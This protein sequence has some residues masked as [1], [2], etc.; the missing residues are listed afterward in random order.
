MNVPV[1]ASMVHAFIS[2]SLKDMLFVPEV[3]DFGRHARQMVESMIDALR[4]P[5]LRMGA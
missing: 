3:L 4:S 1:A 5:A 2:G